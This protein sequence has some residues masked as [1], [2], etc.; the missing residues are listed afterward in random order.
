MGLV[1]LLVSLRYSRSRGDGEFGGQLGNWLAILQAGKYGLVGVDRGLI[2]IEVV[3]VV[4]VSF[5][6]L[7]E[8]LAVT[9]PKFVVFHE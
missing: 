4:D 9:N 5:E 1:G 7:D 2:A 6:H 3:H 8:H